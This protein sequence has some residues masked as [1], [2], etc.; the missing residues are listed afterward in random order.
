M[1][2]I[3]DAKIFFFRWLRCGKTHSLLSSGVRTS[4][5]DLFRNNAGKLQLVGSVVFGADGRAGVVF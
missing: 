4:Q 5:H 3:S 1:Y 2:F